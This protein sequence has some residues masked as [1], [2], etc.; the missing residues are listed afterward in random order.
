MAVGIVGLNLNGNKP[1]RAKELGAQP[2]DELEI[3]GLSP[4]FATPDSDIAEEFQDEDLHVDDI[5][6]KIR[7]VNAAEIGGS[8]IQVRA[9]LKLIEVWVAKESIFTSMALRE[10]IGGVLQ[11]R[12][13]R[14]N[15]RYLV[16]KEKKELMR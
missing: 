1:K 14:L 5:E 6:V 13:H 10:M 3:T 7:F 15:N 4:V 12:L 8:N 11:N 9:T 2:A 16:K